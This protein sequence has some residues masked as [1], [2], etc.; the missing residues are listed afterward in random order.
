[1]TAA[2]IPVGSRVVLV[3]DNSLSLGGADCG[4]KG[5]HGV[6]EQGPDCS[7]YRIAFDNGD[8]WWVNVSAIALESPA[9]AA[10]L[11]AEERDTALG[12][13][14]ELA[15]QLR[16][17]YSFTLWQRNGN[18]LVA[19]WLRDCVAHELWGDGDDGCLPTPFRKVK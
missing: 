9:P 10:P 13:A 16:D 15:D 11:T 1:M 3:E 2:P 19:D 12:M 4:R 6:V 7:D 8:M 14:L 5:S 17:D 18:L